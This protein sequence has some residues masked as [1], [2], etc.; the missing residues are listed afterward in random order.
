[1]ERESD[2]EKENET[3]WI[4]IKIGKDKYDCRSPF[5]Y[6]VRR[7]GGGRRRRGACTRVSTYDTERNWGRRLEKLEKL[8]KVDGM[9]LAPSTRHGDDRNCYQKE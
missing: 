8:E 6:E 9:S 7:K 1:M 3:E 4:E 2:F 5:T